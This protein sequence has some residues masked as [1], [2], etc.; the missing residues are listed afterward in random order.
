MANKRGNSS[1][2]RS[3]KKFDNG[4]GVQ[5]SRGRAVNQKTKAMR[6]QQIYINENDYRH[7]LQEVLYTPEDI[8]ARIFRKDGPALGDQFDPLPSNA[9]PGGKKGC[10]RVLF[11][12][13]LF[14]AVYVDND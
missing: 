1:R 4:N 5:N 2:Q 10:F 13:S 3:N 7:R 14:F 9:F 6:N 8:F 12:F 11:S